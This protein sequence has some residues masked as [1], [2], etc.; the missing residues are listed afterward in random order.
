[1]MTFYSDERQNNNG[2]RPRMANG[3]DSP[4]I[5]RTRA[6]I[7]RGDKCQAPHATLVLICS[8]EWRR[9]MLNLNRQIV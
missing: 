6:F 8:F 7:I 4:L 3:G 5:Y 9:P 2:R 1:M